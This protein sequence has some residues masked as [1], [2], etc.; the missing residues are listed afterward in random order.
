VIYTVTLNPAL[1]RTLWV[2][3][4][5][6]DDS[7]RIEREEKYAGG[8][9]INVSEVLTHL[10]VENRALGFIGGFAGE[11]LEGLLVNQGISCDFVPIS[12]E[13]RTDIIIH[14]MSTESETEFNARGPVIR[15][16]E[17]M[18]M[19]RK[20]ETLEHPDIVVVSG[21][22]PGDVHPE[23]Y[24]KIIEI[25]RTKEARVVLDTDGDALRAGIQGLPSVIKPNIHELS[26]LVGQDLKEMKEIAGAARGILAQGIETVLVSL[27]AQGMILVREDGEYHAVPPRVEAVNTIGA[28]D[29]AVAGF[30]YGMVKGKSMK[31][32][33]VFA[34]AAGTATT[35]KT[36]TAVC[37]DEDVLRLVP[38]VD[39]QVL[40]SSQRQ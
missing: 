26:R 40:A 38:Q 36:G 2:E 39:I 17:L 37:D 14:D 6:S 5:R 4:I 28:G 13:T 3:R 32:S 12:G 27:G 7:N 34:V 29:S 10:G 1:D 24:R 16:Y 23:I 22:L 30:V 35:L 11:E 33:L 8:K 31:D 20:I 19:V 25:S 21:S 9:G 15:P 18:K